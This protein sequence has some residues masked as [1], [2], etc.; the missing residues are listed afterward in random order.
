M[1]IFKPQI[2]HDRKKFPAEIVET[3]D[4]FVVERVTMILRGKEVGDLSL[5]INSCPV[6]ILVFIKVKGDCEKQ[7][8]SG[9]QATVTFPE[10]GNQIED[11]LQYIERED[12]IKFV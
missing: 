6:D 7:K 9:F 1:D 5:F 12:E 11:V 8:A 2:T 10:S 4:S 3:E